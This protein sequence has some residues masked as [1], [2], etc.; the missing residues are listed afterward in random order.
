MV[1]GT[2]PLDLP[3]RLTEPGA[4][5]KPDVFQV[6]SNAT[7][8]VRGEDWTPSAYDT[9]LFAPEKACGSCA[10]QAASQLEQGPAGFGQGR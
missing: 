10:A 3:T 1:H 2:E 9:S 7:R 4:L 5:I 6:L 8:A